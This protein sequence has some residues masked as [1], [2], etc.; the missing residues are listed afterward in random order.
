MRRFSDTET[1]VVPG[2]FSALRWKS[3]CFGMVERTAVGRLF[4]CY[5]CTYLGTRADSN[6]THMLCDPRFASLLNLLSIFRAHLARANPLRIAA[7]TLPD[8]SSGL[9]HPSCSHF[10]AMQQIKLSKKVI[11]LFCS[12]GEF[13]PL[14][15]DQQKYFFP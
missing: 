14:I 11:F 3:P 4:Q 7:S 2:Y 15:A 6:E 1:G 10:G 13:R 12:K 8:E 5:A 9:P